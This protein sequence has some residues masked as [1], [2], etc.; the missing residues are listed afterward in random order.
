[1]NERK[2][3]MVPQKGIRCQDTPPPMMPIV[4]EL[5]RCDAPVVSAQ[6]HNMNEV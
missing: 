3:K 6:S 5:I 2:G 4:T 1:M